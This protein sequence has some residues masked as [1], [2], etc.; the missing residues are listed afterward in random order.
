MADHPSSNLAINLRRLREARGLTQQQLA[1]LSEVPRPTLA[2]LE[3]G[4]AN[5][6]LSVMMK[7]A[8]AL[9]AS[10]EELIA[11]PRRALR[12]Y[13]MESLQLERHAKV[14]IRRVLPEP[15]PGVRLER[16]QLEPGASLPSEAATASLRRY[17]TCELGE[18]ECEWEEQ[19]YCLVAGDVAVVDPGASFRLRNRKRRL[20][21][22]YT[23][24]APAPAG[25]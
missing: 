11:P 13:A 6:T 21:V 5:P 23:L 20:A 24:T 25:Q 16:L 14:R 15:I 2:H 10:I 9:H 22:A 19:A 7:V 3:A 12:H 4:A 18:L 1:E 17:I 8:A